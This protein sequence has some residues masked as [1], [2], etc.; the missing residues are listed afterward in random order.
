MQSRGV[1]GLLAVGR[2][3]TGVTVAQADDEMK[4]IM[5]ELDRRYPDEVAGRGAF[6]EPIHE[7]EVGSS[8]P[9]L[10]LLLAASLVLLLLV[11]GNVAGLM[12][13]RSSE[14]AG[15]VAIRRSLGASRARIARQLVVESTLLGV[16]GGAGAVALAPL[17]LRALR[18]LAPAQLPRLDNVAIDPVVVA[19]LA[20][21]A[22]GTGIVAGLLPALQAGR[23]ANGSLLLAGWRGSV[24]D[25]RSVVRRGLVVVQIAIAVVLVVGAGLVSR[26]LLNL[27][28]VDPGFRVEGTLALDAVLPDSRYEPP[29]F[30]KG[31][32]NWPQ[33]FRFYE[34]SIE[35]IGALPGVE[36]VALALNHPLSP[37]WTS[38]TAIEGRPDAGAPRDESRIRP[39]SPGYFETLGM[40]IVR[41]RALRATDTVASDPVVVVNHTFARK[42]FGD[43]DPTGH[44]VIYWQTPRTIVGVVHDSRF[45]GLD[46]EPE[47]AVYASLFQTPM[48]NVTFIVRTAGE[49]GPLVRPV[50]EAIWSIDPDLALY[51]V[52][53]VGETLARSLAPQR[54]RAAL[55]SFFAGVA[56]LL[57]SVGIYGLIAWHDGLRTREI[58][59]RMALGAEPRG[60]LR[61]VLR[62]GLLLA[63]LG[64]ALGAAAAI[65]A[66]KLVDSLLFGVGR[67]DAATFAVAA[68]ALVASALVATWIPARRAAKL[69]P[70]AALRE[71]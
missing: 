10:R 17:A 50:Q 62:E 40:R 48:S 58:G 5:K 64:V 35:R 4:A 24:G 66:S 25:G 59:V 13:A 18:S 31:Y 56:L 39:V 27:E 38:S 71:E 44:R 41:G 51:H 53:P 46:R 42:Y 69:D 67:L 26:T 7:A 47:P 45:Q 2:L 19:F 28:R 30:G 55:M 15:E 1:H 54:F 52:E 32:P 37:G 23:G 49:P 14:R 33:A 61:L 43:A 3:R 57:A 65:P 21:A 63:A 36:S 29:D 6:V 20:A 22:I 11:C 70:V 34:A 60:V 8:R 9:V 68:A 12:L 16:A